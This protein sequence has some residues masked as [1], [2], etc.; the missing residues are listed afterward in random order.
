MIKISNRSEGLPERD[1]SSPD[2]I[3]LVAWTRWKILP[4][5][6]GPVAHVTNNTFL[7]MNSYIF[8]ITPC[9][10]Y[11]FINYVMYFV[12]QFVFIYVFTG[13][14]T[15]LKNTFLRFSLG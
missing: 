3:G 10:L 6:Q 13:K 4:W 11:Y 8:Y 7:F 15:A 5:A 14:L 2:A 12:L 9:S 1:I